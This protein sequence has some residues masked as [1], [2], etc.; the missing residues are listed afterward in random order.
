MNITHGAFPDGSHV[1]GEVTQL[2]L[3]LEQQKDE[4]GPI[5]LELLE[6]FHHL[7]VGEPTP[8]HADL[9]PSSG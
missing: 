1:S 4:L 5:A 2:M 9:S 7:G 8:E 3:G 6:L